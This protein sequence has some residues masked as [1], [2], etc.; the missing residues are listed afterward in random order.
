MRPRKG[1]VPT[2]APFAVRGAPLVRRPARAS[3]PIV[4]A[5]RDDCGGKQRRCKEGA[6]PSVVVSIDDIHSTKI[7]RS[8]S[9]RQDMRIATRHATVAAAA[10][11]V[12][13][14]I[15]ASVLAAS[16]GS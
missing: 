10:L 13:A 2:E 7:V 5:G 3:P 16:G 1:A 15:P 14:L 6:K 9:R 11:V 8:L 12:A 4:L